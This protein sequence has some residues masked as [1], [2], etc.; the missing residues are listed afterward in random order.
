MADK[1][2]LIIMDSRGRD[3]DYY[4]DKAFVHLDAVLI[5]R[6]GL[7][8]FETYNFAHE[9][10][11]YYEPKLIYVLT[12]ICDLTELRSYDPRLVLLRY[13]TPQAAVY[14]YMAKLDLVHSQIYS[15]MNGRGVCPMIIFP[16]QTGMDM[17]RYSNYPDDLVHPHQRILNQ[18][19]VTINRNVDRQN[20]SMNI[21][22]P[23]L[24][25]PVHTRCRGRVRHIYGKLSDGCHLTPVLRET[26]ASKLYE[27]SLLNTQKYDSY[28]LANHMY[29]GQ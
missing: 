27:N 12:G 19:L 17:G 16:T 26:W 25:S 1:P 9:T 2:I 18:A 14:S 4:I 8:L 10:I 20:N 7:S 24:A 15:L 29:A 23:F 3:I 22:T 5:W 28:V 6:G 11:L 21:S 13:V